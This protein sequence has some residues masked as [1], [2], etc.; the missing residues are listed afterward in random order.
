MCPCKHSQKKAQIAISMSD[1]IYFR[2]SNKTRNKEENF[3]MRVNWSKYI[4]VSSE[5]ALKNRAS[6][7]PW[8]TQTTKASK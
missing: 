2:T 1:K 4:T 6:K 8:K 3:I 7:F 5:Y